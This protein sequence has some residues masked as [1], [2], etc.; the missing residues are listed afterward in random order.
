MNGQNKM[1]IRIPGKQPGRTERIRV[2]FK[3]MCM[4]ALIIALIVCAF[5]LPATAEFPLALVA[6]TTYAIWAWYE[7]QHGKHRKDGKK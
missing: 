2:T 5:G 1:R 7:M 6:L 4:I 3:V